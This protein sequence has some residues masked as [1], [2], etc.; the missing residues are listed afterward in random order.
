ML[1]KGYKFRPFIELLL[2]AC[3]FV[4]AGA[5]RADD[6]QIRVFTVYSYNAPWS[7]KIR[8]AMDRYFQSQK[9]KTVRASYF[10]DYKGL[11]KKTA[12]A[13]QNELEIAVNVVR[14][15]SPD[16]IVICDDEAIL[17]FL[18]MM[19]ELNKPII[20]T[21]VNGLPSSIP[22][23]DSHRKL[24]TGVFE[25]YPMKQTLRLLSDISPRKIHKIKLMTESS[26]TA[27]AI[28]DSI[29]NYFENNDLKYTLEKDLVSNSW[30]EWKEAIANCNTAGIVPWVLLPFDIVDPQGQPV[31]FRTIGDWFMENL[32]VPSL[33]IVDLIIEMGVMASV[34]IDPSTLGNGAAEIIAMNHLKHVEIDKIPFRFPEQSAI[35]IN[36]DAT[37]RLGVKIPI[38]LLEY[39]RI[40][41][42]HGKKKVAK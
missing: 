29:H 22:G 2:V 30:I 28:I 10:L 7:D 5:A 16:Y 35:T 21:G 26:D 41:Q 24:I 8:L 11:N 34:A 37:D 1:N 33:S 9:I 32:R 38:E 39:G 14:K 13:R 36:K 18:P 40:I 17:R 3:A 31:S 20:F 15:F 12:A 4:W 19:Y 42:S 6:G 27:T 25:R 23:L